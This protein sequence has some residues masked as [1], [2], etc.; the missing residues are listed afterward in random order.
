MSDERDPN[1]VGLRPI[2]GPQRT[3][4]RC[5]AGEIVPAEDVLKDLS[6]WTIVWVD[7]ELHATLTLA[8]DELVQQRKRAPA[9]AL[10]GFIVQCEVCPQQAVVATQPEP[11]WLCPRCAEVAGGFGDVDVAQ[12]EAVASFTSRFPFPTPA[13]TGYPYIAVDLTNGQYPNVMAQAGLADDDD[14]PIA[15]VQG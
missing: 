15:K 7:A 5:L 4:G 11:G 9:P 13:R 2:M 12:G 10:L 8:P 6:P 1:L 3:V 14:Y